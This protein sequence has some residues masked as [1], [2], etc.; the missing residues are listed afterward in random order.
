MI[1]EAGEYR[2]YLSPKNGVNVEKILKQLKSVETKIERM[3]KYNT[4]PW[5]R[6]RLYEDLKTIYTPAVK[7]AI[8]VLEYCTVE[9]VQENYDILFDYFCNT[10]LLTEEITDD[11]LSNRRLK[12]FSKYEKFPREFNKRIFTTFKKEGQE[13]GLNSKNKS[14]LNLKGE[15]YC[16][17]F[18]KNCSLEEVEWY[19]EHELKRELKSNAEKKQHRTNMKSLKQKAVIG[20]LTSYG[21]K[22]SK[23]VEFCNHWLPLEERPD[24]TVVKRIRNR[25]VIDDWFRKAVI[26]KDEIRKLTKTQKMID[27]RN[28][29]Y[30]KIYERLE[31]NGGTLSLNEDELVTVMKPR[32]LILKFDSNDSLFH[33]ESSIS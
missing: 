27:S 25:L 17:Y 13:Y 22:P 4:A 1:D 21:E 2:K 33:V 9:S 26:E 20:I 12:V 6:D 30:L 19:L 29:K 28:N 32:Y 14:Q 11:L 7:N 24:Y 23:I 10:C 3:Q 5:V 15:Y 16:V 18:T 31:E 8:D